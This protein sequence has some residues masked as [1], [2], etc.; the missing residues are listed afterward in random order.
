MPDKKDYQLDFY[1]Y[2]MIGTDVF[3]DPE[4]TQRLTKSHELEKGFVVYVAGPMGETRKVTV[5]ECHGGTWRGDDGHMMV[6]GDYQ[7]D[8]YSHE[9][10][11][12]EPDGGWVAGC[13]GD[14]AALA[15]VDF[16]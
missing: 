15:R 14:M 4:M 16:S 2:Q 1:A 8:R 9:V 11:E 5:T 7:S 6:S 10:F 3:A 12:N 13:F